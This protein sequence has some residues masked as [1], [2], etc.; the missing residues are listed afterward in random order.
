MRLHAQRDSRP[1]ANRAATNATSLSRRT[2]GL[3]TLVPAAAAACALAFAPEAAA[4]EAG[5]HLIA[6]L[7]LGLGIAPSDYLGPNFAYGGLFGVGGKFRDFPLRFYF[8]TGADSVNFEGDGTNPNTGTGYTAE[9]T[10]V[11]IFGGLRLLMPIYSQIRVYL[12]ILGGAGYIDGTV[13]R[14]DGPSIGKQDW[15]AEFIGA[16]GLQYRWHEYAS[17]GI[18]AEVLFGGQEA[19]VLDTYAGEG[20]G[21]GVRFTVLVTQTW[22]I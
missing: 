3:R 17:T 10:Y 12:D 7:N 9:R 20:E 11:D 13:T 2:T 14:A 4:G 16:L 21:G 6:E 5:T 1:W 22:H 8:V 15:Y 19:E 18:R